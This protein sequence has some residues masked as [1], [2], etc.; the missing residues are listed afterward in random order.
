M[1]ENLALSVIVFTKNE[2][3]QIEFLVTLHIPTHS[4]Y[5]P[6]RKIDELLNK[7]AEQYAI[8]REGLMGI[9]CS[10]LDDVKLDNE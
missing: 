3:G 2:W 10:D 8:Q 5:L 1:R 7:Y 9:C 4:A 6:K